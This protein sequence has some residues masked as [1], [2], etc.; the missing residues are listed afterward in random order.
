VLPIEQQTEAKPGLRPLTVFVCAE[1]G[2]VYL[3]FIE[4]NGAMIGNV[5]HRQGNTTARQF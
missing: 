4:R 5:M 1:G 2:D 3:Q